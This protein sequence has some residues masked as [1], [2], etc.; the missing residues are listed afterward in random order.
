MVYISPSILS[1]NFSCLGQ[2]ACAMAQAGAD[3]LHVDVMDG[4]FVPNITL[5]ATVLKPV[6]PLTDI[7]FDVHLMIIDP[8]AYIEDFASAGA[9]M[10]TFHLESQSDARATI[11]KIRACHKKAGIAI[12]PNTPVEEV[13]PFIELVDMVLVMTVE[14]GFG[15]QKLIVPT[16]EK[17]RRVRQYANAHK[18]QLLVQVD[19]GINLTTAKA[20]FDAGANVLVAGSALYSQKDYKQAVADLRRTA[21]GEN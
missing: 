2:E 14:P 18:P 16:L 6:R 9:D 4:V 12:K 1:C 19:G 7:L 20:A 8:I 17:V 15:N 21:L 11:E 10:I 13:L 5:G 3:M